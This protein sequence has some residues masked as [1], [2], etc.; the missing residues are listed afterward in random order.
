[1]YK[2][3]KGGNMR[4]LVLIV[5]LLCS[6]T[7]GLYVTADK[8]REIKILQQEIFLLKIEIATGGNLERSKYGNGI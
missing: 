7:V 3:G 1:M 2:K 4:E 5:A 6:A 8:E